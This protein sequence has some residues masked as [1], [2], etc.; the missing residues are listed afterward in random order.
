MGELMEYV[1]E[2][3]S[4]NDRSDT[5]DMMDKQRIKN[6]ILAVCDNHIKGED[7]LVFEVLP[8]GLQ[9]AVAVVTEEPLRSKYDILQISDTLFMARL[10]SV[11]L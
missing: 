3:Y 7:S 10:R 5:K 2:R 4:K 9:Y 1:K 6:S 11:E 8:S